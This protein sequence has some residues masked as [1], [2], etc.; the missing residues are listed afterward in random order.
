MFKA[1]TEFTPTDSFSD[2]ILSRP[3]DQLWQHIVANYDVDEAEYLKKLLPLA[4]PDTA[5]LTQITELAT[6]LI[7]NVRKQ[8]DSVHMVDAL[9]QEYSLDTQEGI[10]LMCLA[11]ALMRIPDKRTADALI[12]DRLSGADWDKHMGKSDSTLV[13]AST[14][15]LLLTGKVVKL[16]RKIDG[17]P[18]NVL[19]RLVKRSG[20]P[21]IR[22][23]MHQAMKIMGKQF[24]LGRDIEEALDHGRKYRAQ[25][26]HYS[27]DML[28]E[29]ALTKQDAKRY[30]ESYMQ[31]I[32][33][34]GAD[35]ANSQQPGSSSISIKLSALHPRYE[36]SQENRVQTE[37]YNDLLKLLEFAREQNVSITIDAE[38]MDRLELSLRLFEKLYRS[39]VNQ[40]WGQLGLVVQAYSKRALPVLVW[41]AALAKEQGDLIPVRLVKGAYWD[42]EIKLC[43]QKG[44]PSYP[45]YTRKEATD[46]SYLACLNFLFSEHSVGRIYPQFATHNA[47]T[48][49][50]VLHF[51]KQSQRPFEFQRLHGMGDALYKAILGSYQLPVRIYAPV[52]AHKD[53][54]PYLVRRLLENGANSSFVHRLVDAETPISSLVKHPALEL[55]KYTHLH[56]HRIALP[57]AI[58]PDRPNSAGVNLFV[59]N[60]Y[61]AL[62]DEINLWNKTQWQACPIIN[63]ASNAEGAGE[64]IVSPYDKLLTVGTVL[65][66]D[67]NHLAAALDSAQ[68]GFPGWNATPAD[69]RAKI[70]ETF[71]DKLEANFAE[72]M[73]LCTREAGKTLQDGIDEIR[74]A[75][76]FCRYYAQ[77]ARQEMSKPTVLPGP[78]GESNELY[79][80]GR[81]IFVCISPWN[82]PLAIFTGQMV[83]ALAA[84]NAVIVKPAEQTTL[85]AH[86][87]VQLLLESGVPTNALQFL[88]GDGAKIGPDLISDPRVTGVAFTGST[89]T[90]H[91]INRTLAA[92]NGAIGTLIAETG[93]QNAMIVDSTA[94]PEQVVKDVVQSSFASAGQRCSALRVLFVQEDI[95]DHILELLSG[96]MQELVVGNPQELKTDV[97]PVIDAEAQNKLISHIRKLSQSAKWQSRANLAQ[98]AEK[99]Y[100]VP[101]TAFEINGI[102]ELSEEQFGPILHI[103]RYKA[104]ELDNIINSINATGFGLTLGIHSRNESTALYIERSVKVGN[105]Y[106]NRNQIGAVVGVQPFGGRGLSGTGPKAGGPHYLHRFVTERTRTINTTAVGGNATLLS[107]GVEHV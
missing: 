103:V 61:L 28:G 27:F 68:Q 1:P 10:L 26:Y 101:P 24:V 36:Q 44:L 96:A 97:G 107:L 65:W 23:A 75:V 105:T 62:Q 80:E 20:E 19:N 104:A 15:G 31:A 90:A 43:Q 18:A 66:S 89:Q 98:D 78:T 50:C 34:V 45:V 39:P 70:L 85:I 88:P 48:A 79:L 67:K 72:L 7:E 38:E 21:V 99:G 106:I 29:A 74:E 11:E 47:H 33:A 42:S 54:L 30:M 32:A 58:Y 8:D 82:F 93:G 87:A 37:L 53:L 91:I 83:A 3:L 13:N 60:Q 35:P 63:G 5:G 86:R 6:R 56:N 41:L 2:D 102:E 52:G 57:G 4:Q 59:E 84:G 25:G 22:A 49:A 92:R 9:L 55:Q 76:D 40:G 71:A 81:G 94:L 95:A 69:T 64:T 51:A 16:D 12:K 100:F 77:Q 17:R 46:V 14:W 73:A